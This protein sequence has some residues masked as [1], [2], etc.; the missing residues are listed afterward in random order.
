MSLLQYCWLFPIV[1]IG[2]CGIS[3]LM[4]RGVLTWML[5]RQW[6]DI[7]NDRS[8]HT[9]PTPRGGGLVIVV[10]CL[11]GWSVFALAGP[12][13]AAMPFWSYFLAALMIAAVS[14]LD[15]V[16]NLP[17]RIRFLVHL[18]AACLV[19]FTSRAW[20][21]LSLP[22]LGPVSLGYAGLPLCLIW[23]VGLTNAYNFMDGIDGIAGGQAVAAGLGWMVLGGMADVPGAAWL[24]LLIAGASLGFLTLNRPPAKI[25]MGDVGSAF[26]GFS[27]AYLAVEANDFNSRLGVAGALLVWPFVFDSAL[28]FFRRLLKGENVFAAH[29]SHLYQRL[30]QAGWSHGKV[31]FLYTLLAGMGILPAAIFL[32][33]PAVGSW[34]I[35]GGIALM[36]GGLWLLTV[37]SEKRNHALRGGPMPCTGEKNF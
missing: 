11:A 36:A 20:A 7:P 10:I 4:V 18:A 2:L 9:Q 5:R 34:L 14:A 37:Y 33:R 19:I 12:A 22:L 8:S 31:S 35:L 13:T 30:V 25:F 23:I 26:L 3:H 16:R 15:D 1:V 24:G 21:S 27:F 6:F 28:T 17:N 29:R 32:Q